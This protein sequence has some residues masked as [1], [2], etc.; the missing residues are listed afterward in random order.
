MFSV[1]LVVADVKGSEGAEGAKSARASAFGNSAVRFC[2]LL[3]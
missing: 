3:E 2:D 1:F